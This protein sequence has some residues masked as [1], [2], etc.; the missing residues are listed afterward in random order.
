MLYDLA[1]LLFVIFYLP[2]LIFKGKLHKGFLERF[3]EYDDAKEQALWK[4]KDTIWIQ[5]VS[6]GEVA[7]C[8]S[9]IPEL[10]RKFPAR[11]IVLS[12]ITRTG[13][14][15]A[16][17]FFSKDVIVI[18]F[19]L[20][21][22]HTVRAVIR[23]IRPQLYIMIETEIWPNVLEEL[24]LRHVRSILV[25]GRISDRSYGK[26]KIVRKFLS[27]AL[28]GIDRFCMQSETDA[29]RIRYLGAENDKVA[30]TGNMKFDTD[31]SLDGKHGSVIK[32]LLGIGEDDRVFVAGST[33]G[34]EEEAIME[35]YKKL[36]EHFPNLKLI[37]APRHIERADEVQHI[38]RRC[39]F[40]ARKM[41]SVQN[42]PSIAADT[43]SRGLYPVF[44]IDAIGYLNDAYSIAD[45]V[46]VGGSLIPHGG[47][48]P[49]EPAA[50]GKAVIFG[51]Y[52]FNFRTVT[53]TL[54][55]D[56]AAI[57]VRDRQELFLNADRLLMNIH[58]RKTLGD[59]ALKAVARNRGAMARNLEAIKN[60]LND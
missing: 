7:L 35:V 18:Y 52:M 14:E 21:F 51:P 49:I 33:H 13:N 11:S 30:V 56:H 60:L 32:Q 40:D 53:T 31:A 44:I 24:R 26:Y 12:T 48:N 54:L 4:A 5:A 8:K 25:N 3:G 28:R 43:L 23:K 29:D 45:L 42:G 15:L 36:V 47:Q 38:I 59:N 16:K 2:T 19:P 46:F 34:G 6:V 37:I 20:D 39:G 27:S 50:L 9:L 55:K 17:K 22:S 58:E 1:F 57:Q 41:T 10:R